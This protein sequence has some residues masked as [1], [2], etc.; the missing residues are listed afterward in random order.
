MKLSIKSLAPTVL[1]ISIGMGILTLIS[2]VYSSNAIEEL[3]VAQVEQLLNSTIDNYADW[4]EA[5]RADLDTWSRQEVCIAAL[6]QSFIGISA[7]KSF[8]QDL[9]KLKA[10]HDYYHDVFLVDLHGKVIAA[11]MPE[12]T[13]EYSV[14]DTDPFVRA[15][16][17]AMAISPVYRDSISGKP[18]FAMAM[19]VLANGK[20]EG[21]LWMEFDLPALNKKFI[22]K[23]KI[24]RSGKVFIVDNR[25]GRILAHPD[26]SAILK[27]NIAN[28]ALGRGIFSGEKGHLQITLPIGKSQR[29]YLVVYDVLK[30]LN[31]KIAIGAD[32][33]ELN[34]PIIGIRNINIIITITIICVACLI[35]YLITKTTIIRPLQRL[36]TS[37]ERLSH[38][39]LD[40]PIDVGRDDELGSL[41]RSFAVMRDAIKSQMRELQA[42]EKK[43]RD[44][45][46]NAVEGIFQ[47]SP[48]G[49][50]ISANKAMATIFGCGS[51][52][53]LIA[54][55][56]TL[57]DHYYHPQDNRGIPFAGPEE[58]DA[59]SGRERRYKR[60]DGSPFWGFESV[61]AVYDADGSLLHYDGSLVDIT[62]RRE[63]EAA[64]RESHERLLIVL[65]SLSA[66]VYVTDMKTYE[67]LFI[68]KY[69]HDIFGDV[70]GKI[71]WQT[72]QAGQT[73]PCVFCTNDRLL[74]PDGTPAAPY[75]W[76]FQNTVTKRW[77]YIQDRAIPWVDG[78]TVRMEI[79]TDI[80]DRKLIEEKTKESLREKELLLSEIHHRVK[81]NMQII[82]SLLNFQARAIQ[83]SRYIEMFNESQNRIRSMALIH[84]KLYRSEDFAN[85]DFN[86]Y[87][88]GLTDALF[89]FYRINPAN[90]VL[91]TV[92]EDISLGIDTAIPCGLIINE[93]ISNALKHAFPDGRKGNIEV[94]IRKVGGAGPGS[95]YEL[96]VSD[97]GVGIS[98]DLDIRK[99]D[100]LGMQLV[101]ALTEHQLQGTWELKRKDPG[102][103]V[104]IRFR[105]QENRTRVR[106]FE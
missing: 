95:W 55:R 63:A 67:I 45:F 22:D 98:G 15:L 28:D 37:A 18:V 12:K 58:R 30:D 48:D 66:V 61:R 94:A 40:H 53:E 100:S 50:I 84:E 29:E 56:L 14:A 1:L 76:E 11:S 86:S 89:R 106:E 41:A 57:M 46:E 93:L 6:E 38:G 92:I 21:Q 59:L 27:E 19:P 69:T 47:L 83:D 104:L 49:R 105:K 74:G 8:T 44:I 68:N 75:S 96:K 62:E 82:S 60:K 20:I 70:Q 73:G 65:N 103:E 4:V 97:D 51:P 101:I 34:A 10:R 32:L 79:A 9:L 31:W 99:T 36:Q 23:I 42:A 43:Y 87:V 25:D 52:E 5:R 54:S 78:R 72:F 39:S 71:C 91:K 24:G 16:D 81:N 77:Y 26:P 13:G 88:K 2:F 3:V 102:T 33:E 35:I 85:V 7:R 17:G 80:T 64:A 90:V